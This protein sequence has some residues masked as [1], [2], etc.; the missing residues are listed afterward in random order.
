MGAKEKLMQIR[1]IDSRLRFLQE[2]MEERK[3]SAERITPVLDKLNVQTSPGNTKEDAIISYIES[4]RK[5]D[6]LMKTQLRLKDSVI[7]VLCRIKEEQYV[8]ILYKRYFEFKTW[9]EIRAECHISK[10][11]IFRKHKEAL[12]AFEDAGEK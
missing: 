7:E 5:L 10:G 4:T 11:S 9:E 12:K 8:S 6:A 2:Q 1:L 3:A